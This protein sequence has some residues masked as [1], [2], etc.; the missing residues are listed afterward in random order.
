MQQFELNDIIMHSDLFY[1]DPALFVSQSFVDKAVVRLANAYGVTRDSLNVVCATH[2][3]NTKAYYLCYRLLL[4]V[5]LPS[6]ASKCSKAARSSPTMA[7]LPPPGTSFRRAC[8]SSLFKWNQ[9]RLLCS[10][11]RRTLCFQGFCQRATWPPSRH[12]SW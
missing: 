6:A 1:M 5:D 2:F 9:R 10:W 12:A 7:C 8:N 11:W 4:L 3:F